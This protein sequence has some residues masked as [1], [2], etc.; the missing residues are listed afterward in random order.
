MV[1]RYKCIKYAKSNLSITNGNAFINSDMKSSENI[2]KSLI[3]S[4]L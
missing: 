1:P 2:T 4:R 3:I